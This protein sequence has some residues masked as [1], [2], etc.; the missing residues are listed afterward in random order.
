MFSPDLDVVLARAIAASMAIPGVFDPV[1]IH[2]ERF[3]D[4]SLASELP[5]KEAKMMASANQFVIA[6]N[7]GSRP[8]PDE[9]P[10]NVIAML[11]WATRIKSLYLRQYKKAYADVLI[12]PLVGFTQWHDF[13]IRKRKLKK[14]GR[15]RW[16]NC[17]RS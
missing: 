3:V 6:V 11:D 1:V 7:V 9:E 16:S 8:H 13:P 12:E 14:A 17:R 4:G 10:K 5:A 2:G 15:R